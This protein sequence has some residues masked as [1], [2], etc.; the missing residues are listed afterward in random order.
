MRTSDFDYELPPDRIAQEPAE[1]RDSSRLMVLD[2]STGRV[3]H[4]HFRDLPEFLHPHDA[5]ILN[6]TRVIPARLSASKLPD[7]GKAEILLLK[8]RGPM[9]WEVM[10]GGKG[11]R[12]GRQLEVK[13][14][15]RCEVL[16]DLGGPRRLVQF[17][18]PIS[19]LLDEIGSPPVPPYIRKPLR[20]A[21]QY[22]TVYARQPG[23]AAAPT[24]GLHFTSDVLGDIER[25]GVAI[26]AVTLHIGLDT[27]APVTVEAP[28][29]HPIHTEWCRVSGA[30]V[31]A[32]RGALGAGGRVIAVGTTSV[33]ALET[34]S[35]RSTSQEIIRSFEGPTDL[36]ILP[37]YEFRAV[38]A[39]LTNFHLPRSTLLMMVAAFAGRK[40]IL[41]A[42][43][44]AISEGYR[45]YSFG[46]AMLIL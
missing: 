5:L 11:I 2:R 7:G 28:E 14:R 45:F 20:S 39:M 13:R 26:A 30:V 41:D 31:S 35:R 37:G 25:R 23:S 29:R 33:R 8:R 22:Q 32:V 19:P 10:V 1:P 40:R 16:E 6:E 18:S 15:L 44:V 12:P 3:E 36:F 9:A 38:G 43:D 34:A 21:N 24:A 17:S 27:F 42:Y 4:Y 46:D